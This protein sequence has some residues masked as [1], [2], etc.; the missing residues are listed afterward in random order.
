MT[1]N[2]LE[3][4][5]LGKKISFNYSEKGI[6]YSV[7]GLR[8]IMAWVFLQAG[9]QKILEDDWSSSG[10][11]ENAVADANPFYQLFQW[12]ATHPELV[13]PMVMYGQAVIGIALL[14]GIF[15]RLAALAGSLQMLLFWMASIEGGLLQGIPVE[16]GFIVNETLVYIVLLYGL[17]ALGAGRITGLD[18]KIEQHPIVEKYPKLR[19]ILG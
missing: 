4:E 19:Y 18:K 14:L 1:Q 7:L 11:L 10:F 12:F 15:F 16:H 17:G 6:G 5:L 2:R 8:F 13:D 3:T 9:V